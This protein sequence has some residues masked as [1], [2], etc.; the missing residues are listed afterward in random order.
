VS[1]KREKEST[2][3]SE[4]VTPTTVM[5]SPEGSTSSST[6]RGLRVR[7]PAQQRPYFHHA[8]LFDEA[9]VEPENDGDARSAAKRSTTKLAQVVYPGEEDMTSEE[10]HDQ[11]LDDSIETEP[12]LDHGLDPEQAQEPKSM[13]EPKPEPMSELKPEPMPEPELAVE[14]EP[15][16]EPEPAPEPAPAPK[17]T[18]GKKP[19]GRPKG[20]RSKKNEIDE[21]PEFNVPKN[22]LQTIQPL[23][24]PKPK[25]K[26]RTRKS[27]A[28]SE[29]YVLD[30]SEAEM[31]RL[32]QSD[33]DFDVLHEVSP[34]KKH[35]VGDSDDGD[36]VP[37]PARKASAKTTPKPGGRY[38]KPRTKPKKS[39]SIVVS[40][41]DDD[42]EDFTMGTLQGPKRS[43]SNPRP[44]TP[45]W[46]PLRDILLMNAQIAAEAR[47]Q[48]LRNGTTKAPAPAPAAPTAPVAPVAPVAPATS[49]TQATTAPA[50]TAPAA[51]APA[52]TA[53]TATAPNLTPQATT[54]PVITAPVRKVGRPRKIVSNGVGGS[55]CKYQ[56]YEFIKSD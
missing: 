28:L 53:P 54:T 45:E 3:V 35:V 29:A 34:K 7:T 52:A 13:S 14:P 30:S 4:S 18:T 37:S 1:P 24:D 38:S 31:E 43:K 11:D 33:E 8:K 55:Q 51:T 5:D 25:R 2:P 42:D 36:V 47:L 32:A 49:A 48:H 16:P 39:A 26:S 46:D 10:P 12:E 27:L 20:R 23:T 44:K 21:D 50:A 17:P 40:S 6:R 15:E 41:D 22:V 9:E 56:A 19:L